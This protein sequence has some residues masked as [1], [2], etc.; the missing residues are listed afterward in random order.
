MEAAV[1]WA[2]EVAGGTDPGHALRGAGRQ[3]EEEQKCSMDKEPWTLH[4]V[5]LEE[6]NVN[7]LLV[8]CLEKTASAQER[9]MY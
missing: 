3:A 1:V 4:G 7:P 9:D 6:G 8:S 5:K 2:L